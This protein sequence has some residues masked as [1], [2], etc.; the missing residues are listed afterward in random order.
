MEM[1]FYA[2]YGYCAKELGVARHCERYPIAKD[3][4]ELGILNLKV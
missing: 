1:G 4:F 2:I 3:S